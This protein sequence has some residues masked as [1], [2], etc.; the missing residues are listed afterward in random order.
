MRARVRQALLRSRVRHDDAV[1][2]FSS[3][4]KQ[5]NVFINISH[6]SFK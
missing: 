1:M 4:R 3:A 5:I 6:Y 2:S